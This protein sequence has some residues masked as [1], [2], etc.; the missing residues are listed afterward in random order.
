MRLHCTP[1]TI[2]QKLTVV[3]CHIEEWQRVMQ[4]Q[5]THHCLVEHVREPARGM[6]DLLALEVMGMRH[7]HAQTYMQAEHPYT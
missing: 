2:D 3:R 7:T 6:Q 4:E 1:R 5:G